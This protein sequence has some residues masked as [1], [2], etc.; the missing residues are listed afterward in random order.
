MIISGCNMVD[1]R[2][3]VLFNFI[4]VKKFFGD[5]SQHDFMLAALN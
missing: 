3:D 2:Q 5:S 1:K 4:T